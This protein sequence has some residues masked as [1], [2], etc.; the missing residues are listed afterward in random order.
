LNL[1]F[2]CFLERRAL[3]TEFPKPRSSLSLVSICM[4]RVICVMVI[5][6]LQGA[7]GLLR[8]GRV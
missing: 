6:G 7:A 8:D 3:G 5:Q 2:D 4:L 1:V